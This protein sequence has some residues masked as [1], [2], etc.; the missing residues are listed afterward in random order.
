MTK[1]EAHSLTEYIVEWLIERNGGE[2]AE[3]F[4]NMRVR[5]FDGLRQELTMILEHGGKPPNWVR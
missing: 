3:A 1:D 4:G 2:L 5:D